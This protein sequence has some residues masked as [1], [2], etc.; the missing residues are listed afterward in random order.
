MWIDSEV[1]LTQ[2]VR[3]I[4]PMEIV[5]GREHLGKL[6]IPPALPLEETASKSSR[7]SRGLGE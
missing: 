2:P 6:Q 4:E 3:S 5:E 7:I 1:A